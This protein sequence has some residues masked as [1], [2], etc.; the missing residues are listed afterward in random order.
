MSRSL[1]R[2]VAVRTIS[3]YVVLPLSLAALPGWFLVRALSHAWFVPHLQH[4]VTQQLEQS[5]ADQREL[6]RLAP[7]TAA[8]RR[9]RFDRSEATLRRLQVLALTRQSLVSR[10]ML[11]LL[12]G[13]VLVVAAASTVHLVAR[14]RQARRLARLHASLESLAGGAGEVRVS[15]NRRDVLG[16]VA[17]MIEQV[18][19]TRARDRKRL[20]SLDALSRWQEAARRHAHEMRTPLTAAQLD[21]ERLHETIEPITNT[22]LRERIAG[23]LNG[24][25]QDLRRL[26][27]FSQAYAAFGRLPAPKLERGDLASFVAQFVEQFSGA[28]PGLELGT[29]A[30]ERPCVACFDRELVRQVLVNLCENAAVALKDEGRAHGHLRID[31]ARQS[32]HWTLDVADDGPGLS[33]AARAKLFQPYASSR[34]GGTGLGLPISRKIMLDHG[35]DLEWRDSLAGA[36]FRATLPA[37][38]TEAIA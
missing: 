36:C 25:D 8:V 21:I 32:D 10:H 3:L 38:D 24:L 18:S 1:P 7:A 29:F 28:W 5:L 6:A 9:Q 17:R 14:A 22:V 26:R 34:K 19:E 11:L 13:G 12:V 27:Q 23:L 31:L 37:V 30:P 15:D 35:G 4:D 16:R 33:P 2:W 20:A